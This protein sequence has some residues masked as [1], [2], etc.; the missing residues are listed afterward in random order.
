ML[1][2]LPHAKS[3]H[4]AALMLSNTGLETQPGASGLEESGNSVAGRLYLSPMG[5]RLRD[6][7]QRISDGIA[8]QQLWAQFRADARSSYQFYSKEVDK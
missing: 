5:R 6:F 7:W 3:L 4:G 1:A 2:L 8:I